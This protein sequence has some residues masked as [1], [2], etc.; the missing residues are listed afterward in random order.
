MYVLRF[1]QQKK[2]T[3]GRA[4]FI[5]INKI[6]KTFKHLFTGKNYELF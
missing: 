2:K 1:K 3:Q 4:I 6:L 5:V